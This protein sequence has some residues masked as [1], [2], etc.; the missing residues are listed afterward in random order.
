LQNTQQALGFS[1]AALKN[2]NALFPICLKEVKHTMFFVDL[3]LALVVALVLSAI[4]SAAFR[5]RGPW[6]IWWIFLLVI[7]LAT[8]AGGVWLTPFGPTLFDVAWL[9]FLFVGL[10]FTLILAA[11]VPPARPPRTYSEAVAEVRAEEAA[12]A[13]FSIFFWIML[14]SL[15]IVIVLG[16]VL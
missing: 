6:G 13:A 12:V 2:P 15:I 9:P 10:I 11:V 5:I 7:F 8:W 16:Y 14:I 4:F 1:E 3:L